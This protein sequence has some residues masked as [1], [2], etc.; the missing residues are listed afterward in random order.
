MQNIDSNC[1]YKPFEISDEEDVVHVIPVSGG[2]DSSA[3]ALYMHD[4][5]PDRKFI[6]FFSDTGAEE[7]STYE[8]LDLIEQKIGAKIER[9]K[10][11]KDL[12]QLIDS[13][14]GYLPSSQSRYCTRILKLNSFRDWMKKYE[15]QNMIMYVGIRADEATRVAFS[16]EGVETVMPF[17]EMGWG[18]DKVFSFLS[19]RA[20]I[21][22]QY[23]TRTRSG[24]SICPFVRRQETVGLLQ[25]KPDEF[26]R[27]MALEKVEKSDLD[28]H[29]IPDTLWKDAKLAP[30]WVSFPIP[31]DDIQMAG[32]SSHKSDLFESRGIFVAVEFFYSAFPG[33]DP[34]IWHQRF[35][36]YSPKLHSMK[37][38]VDDR[39]QHLL[40]TAE[41]YELSPAEIRTD[42]R[43][44]IYYIE[45]PESSFDPDGPKAKSF[46]WHNGESY[47]QV[48]HITEWAMR[49]LHFEGLS[50]DARRIVKSELSVE[51]EWTEASKKAVELV[52]RPGNIPT[53]NVVEGMWYQ[54]NEAV[55]VLD[56]DEAEKLMP[57]PMCHI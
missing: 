31:K 21:P 1:A 6:H 52:L 9:I 22:S 38:Q 45:A 5:F 40:A 18:R 53:G 57:C 23:Q 34:F 35:I 24:C 50:Q 25:R 4:T 2:A 39:Y 48:Q 17:K 37:T 36:S 15:N 7:S 54:P 26:K 41:V 43:F 19:Q 30:N 32:N 8:Y 11:E 49:T 56:K 42:A 10:P 51:Y 47:A 16:V 29:T 46:T 28:R 20:G 33:T 13:F 3:L 55:R 27:G 44:A 12:F 14:S